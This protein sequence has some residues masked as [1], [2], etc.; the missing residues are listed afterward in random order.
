MSSRY[1]RVSSDVFAEY[2]ERYAVE[3]WPHRAK[4]QKEASPDGRSTP[5]QE[6]EAQRAAGNARNAGSMI[7]L[8]KLYLSVASYRRALLGLSTC[9]GPTMIL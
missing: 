9:S 3:G 5:K 1:A 4:L 8:R 2:G 6:K 7:S